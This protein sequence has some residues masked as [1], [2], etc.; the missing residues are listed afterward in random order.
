M[1]D[2]D[3]LIESANN[4]C[5]TLRESSENELKFCLDVCIELEKLS[6]NTNK[7]KESLISI[8]EELL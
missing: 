3:D 4:L 1:S 7:T 6:R 2:I 8:K 5:K